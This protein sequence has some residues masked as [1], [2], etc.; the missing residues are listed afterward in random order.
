MFVHFK[1]TGSGIFKRGESGSETLYTAPGGTERFKFNVNIYRKERYEE[2]EKRLIR[3]L[4]TPDE[5]V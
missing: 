4:C 5:C 3:V 1:G 2:N